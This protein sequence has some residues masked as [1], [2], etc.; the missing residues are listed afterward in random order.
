MSAHSV[1]PAADGT[2]WAESSDALAASGM[3][4]LS[5]CQ[6][7]L[8]R[9]DLK[10]CSSAPI[11]DPSGFWLLIAT[12]F[13]SGSGASSSISPKRLANATCASSDKFCAGNTR[14]AYSWKACS[15]AFQ[16]SASIRARSRPVTTALSVAS[17]GAIFGSMGSPRDLAGCCRGTIESRWARIR[18]TS[19][20]RDGAGPAR[21]EGGQEP[22]KQGKGAHAVDGGDAGE[23]SE[24]AEGGGAQAPETER[25][26]VEHPGGQTHPTRQELL[27]IDEDGREGRGHDHGDEHS[28]N[29]GPEQVGV[30]QEQ[31][32]GQGPQDRKPHDGLA[33]HAITDG[34][35]SKGADHDP[36]E[37]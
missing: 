27:R 7:S 32:E 25:E 13:C 3:Y 9:K 35:P 23:V 34:T 33:S 22:E 30:W 24:L 36:D 10:R 12:A 2:T 19:P 28:E 20:H 8:P 29:A 18:G 14:T 5:V 6:P 26:A 16:V 11:T 21:Q 37:E 17:I 15:T 1:S 4:E 31:R